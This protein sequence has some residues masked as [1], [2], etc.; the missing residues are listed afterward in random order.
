MIVVIAGVLLLLGFI[1]ALRGVSVSRRETLFLNAVLNADGQFRKYDAAFRARG[2]LY[3]ASMN[4]AMNDHIANFVKAAHI[5]SAMAVVLFVLAAVP[6]SLGF[7]GRRATLVD[8]KIVTPVALTSRELSDLGAQ[9]ASLRSDLAMLGAAND[10]VQQQW[11]RTFDAR[12]TKV[13]NA[14][15]ELG[16]TITSLEAYRS[17]PSARGHASRR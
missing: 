3:C 10:R 16:K 5:F 13:E 12:M 2:L 4:T 6:T 9:V 8:A 14:I 1:C 15:S 17:P 7:S 11:F